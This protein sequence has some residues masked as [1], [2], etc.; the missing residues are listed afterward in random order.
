MPVYGWLL[1]AEGGDPTLR[2]WAT[3]VFLLAMLTD[4]VDGELARGAASS[5]TSARSP[6]RSPTRPSSRMAFVAL[7]L[8]ELPWWVT[9]VVLVGSGA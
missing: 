9:V 5:P 1:L 3:G 6:A 8:D 7:V 4:R 2:F